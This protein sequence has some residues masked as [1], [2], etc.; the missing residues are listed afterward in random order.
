MLKNNMLLMAWKS[1][2]L[3]DEII[4]HPA[5]WDNCLNLRIDYFNNPKF[6]LHFSGNF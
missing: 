1:R 4:K 6:W 5:N 2:G 3:P